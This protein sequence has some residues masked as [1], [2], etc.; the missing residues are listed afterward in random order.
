MKLSRLFCTTLV[1]FCAAA[2]CAVR[3]A[4]DPRDACESGYASVQ[5]GDLDAG[6]RAFEDAL[7]IQPQ[8]APAK[9][10]VDVLKDSSAGLLDASQTQA[11]VAAIR[12]AAAG[13]LDEALTAFEKVFSALKPSAPAGQRAR[14]QALIANVHVLKK[15]FKKAI[16]AYDRAVDLNPS[17]AGLRHDRGITYATMGAYD[18]ALEDLS[19]AIEIDPLYKLAYFYRAN[20]Y[21]D[22]G[23]FDQAIVDY[24][25]VIELDP[26]YVD[27]YLNRGSLLFSEKQR[28]QDALADFSA[29]IG[30]DNRNADA[31]Y[32][33]GVIYASSGEH[34]R[35]LGD[36]TIAYLLDPRNSD[37][38]F[39]KARVYEQQGRT[40]E[41]LKL[42]R[43]FIQT[44]GAGQEEYLA[45]AQQR[46]AVL[47]GAN[48][49][50]Q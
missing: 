39:A 41:A 28:T 45:A 49:Q 30:L 37:A 44:A 48:A 11:M 2:A 6:R 35:A 38:Y 43:E 22:T 7:R 8:Y 17:A 18:K 1:F 24:T 10:A 25:K 12:D 23:R 40:A 15:D 3:P 31:Y 4:Q 42:Y 34:E 32:N 27:A 21:A 29:A 19:R 14:L 26:A 16:A 9:L 13:R 46:I 47:S 36:F 33:R 5:Q 20:A 50:V